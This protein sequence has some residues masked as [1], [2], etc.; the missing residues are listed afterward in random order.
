M[1]R[2]PPR[3]TLF[4]YTT[5]FRSLDRRAAGGADPFLDLLGQLAVVRIARRQLDPAVGH[6]DERLPE[7]LVG[8]ADGA[9][10]GARGGAIGAVEEDAALVPG[11]EG[12][13]GLLATRKVKR[14]RCATSPRWSMISW[15]SMTMP[16]SRIVR[17]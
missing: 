17:R 10:V 2:R 12:H 11:I 8:E 9:E 7:I 15:S 14:P 5:L 13:A 16:P 1:I 3:S 4:P 6:A